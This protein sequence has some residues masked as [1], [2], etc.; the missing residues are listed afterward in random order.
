[1]NKNRMFDDDESINYEDLSHL[2]FESNKPSV[3]GS[4]EDGDKIKCKLLLLY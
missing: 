3:C 1:M 4:V 2:K